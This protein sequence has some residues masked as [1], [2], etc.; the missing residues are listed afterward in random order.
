VRISLA[1]SVL[2]IWLMMVGG[3]GGCDRATGG[4]KQGDPHA[5]SDDGG[6]AHGS[7]NDGLDPIS[8][9]LFTAKLELFMEYPH[10]VKG[11]PARFLAHFSVLATGEP[12]REGSL[13]FEITPLSG[14]PARK[15]WEAPKRD[16]LFVPEWTF[17]LSGT[18]RLRLLVDSPQVQDV[19]D[20]GEIVVHPDAHEAEHAAEA[21]GGDDPPD[22][23]PFLMEQ[24]WKIGTLVGQA[25]QRTLVERL[26][27]PAQ[28]VAPQGAS[29]V[30]SPP[31]AGRLLP[32]PDGRLPRVGDKVKVGQVLAMIEPPLPVTEVFQL[33]A[34]RAQV[35]ALETELAL[36]ELDLDTKALEVERALIQSQ[37]K[38]E[39]ARRAN[40][41]VASLRE[42]GVGTEQQYDEAQQILRLAEAE[43]EAT[44][45]MKRSYEDA[46]DRLARLWSQAMPSAS[47]LGT[48]VSSYRMPLLA[49][50][51][52]EVVSVA[53]IEGEHLDAAH[54]EV[55]RIVNVDHVWIVG[56][57]SEFDLARLAETPSA[58]LTLPSYPDRRLDILGSGGRLVHVGKVVDP[59]SRTVSVVFELPNRDGLFRVG[60]FAEV[61]V[62]TRKSVDAVAIPEEAIVM[63]NGRP[64][65]FVLSE[66]ERFQRREL[67]LGVRDS[68]FVEVKRGVELGERVI[69]KGAYAVKLAA[70]S[71]ASFGAGHVH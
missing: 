58:S 43:N 20:V 48:D 21:T 45:A 17:D 68:G 38:L 60:M 25:T 69:T 14:P 46:R 15:T 31:V 42:K 64:I 1:P 40:D 59:Q 18:C 5:H 32:P 8:V 24:Q 3:V 16:G 13:T 62:E 29:A 53:H 44:K 30:V 37:A 9:T 12:I 47:A 63:D 39:Y 10:L 56:N 70:R 35:H 55:F 54:Q 4:G 33:S 65:A 36:R 7:G 41:R 28:I 27:V 52:G 26:P 19:V 61:H 57:I 34:N 71:P 49:P 50:I 22:L 2:L 51:S 67:E 11:V 6:H 66:G 23:V